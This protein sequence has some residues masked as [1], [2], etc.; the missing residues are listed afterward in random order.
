MNLFKKLPLLF[1]FF[2]VTLSKALFG[3]SL[4]GDDPYSVTR[5]GAFQ[6]TSNSRSLAIG[7]LG[8]AAPSPAATNNIN[9]ALL[10]INSRVNIE[11]N[12]FGVR[13]ALLAEESAAISG[14]GGLNLL[15]FN[16]PVMKRIREKQ[17]IEQV[18]VLGLGLR[19]FSVKGYEFASVTIDEGLTTVRDQI[20][21]GSVT[22]LDF[23]AGINL[24]QRLLVGVGVE[25]LFGR[26]EDEVILK[27][28]FDE[29]N[30]ISATTGAYY[31]SLKQVSTVSYDIGIAYRIPWTYK[32]LSDD[33]L[34]DGDSTK[35]NFMVGAHIKGPFNLAGSETVLFGQT[36]FAT[37]ELDINVDEL[38]EGV[39]LNEMSEVERET[40]DTLSNGRFSDAMPVGLGFGASVGNGL[41]RAK[42]LYWQLALEGEF[43]DF[44]QL[45]SSASN[46]VRYGTLLEGRLGFEATPYYDLEL[47]YLNLITYRVGLRAGRS[48]FT[49]D[50]NPLTN[51]GINFGLG[52]P[53]TTKKVTG[54]R[55]TV[56]M[57]NLYSQYTETQA[58]GQGSIDMRTWNF[59]IGLVLNDAGWFFKRS[60]D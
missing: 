21:S 17:K 11:T 39:Y 44:S 4:L 50:N 35:L 56:P 19:P 6:S 46:R 8:I 47:G 10:P 41:F 30:T 55:T 60:Y 23:N 51:L 5:F 24:T 13:R 14:G 45:N 27:I 31:S 58:T 28:P 42:R 9:P 38:R 12:L 1:F 52:L 59:G 16:F 36:Y 3:Q 25:Y 33:S 32:S 15:N 48:Q 2:I 53:L 49:I 37:N 26:L 20:G 40:L 43:R 57:I 29:D 22:A 34:V 7:N 18:L 54:F